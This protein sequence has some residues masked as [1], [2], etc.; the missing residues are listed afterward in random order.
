MYGVLRCTP[1]D[2]VV[3]R[4][5][6]GHGHVSRPTM[7]FS[8]SSEVWI[9]YEPRIFRDALAAHVGAHPDRAAFVTLFLTSLRIDDGHDEECAHESSTILGSPSVQDTMS[10]NHISGNLHKP[11]EAPETPY[12]DEED[13]NYSQYVLA[14][15]TGSH[16]PVPF[17]CKICN[18][19]PNHRI[20]SGYLIYPPDSEAFQQRRFPPPQ[21]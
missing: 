14:F 11:T 10:P 12:C 20:V 21:S 15:E 6:I 13:I 9:E 1:S 18:L 2:S 17:I 16:G 19:I 3:G 8:V 5:S 4:R 7:S